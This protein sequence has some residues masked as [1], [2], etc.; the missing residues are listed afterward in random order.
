MA[1]GELNTASSTNAVAIGK[2]CLHYFESSFCLFFLCFKG[3]N[4]TA[5]GEGA[6]ALG[7]SS[8]ATARFAVTIPQYYYIPQHVSNDGP[9]FTEPLSLLANML[10]QV[11]NMPLPK[12]VMR[13]V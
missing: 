3:F 11:R 4:N 10:L 6:V 2:L 13:K 8:Q 9:A 12:A 7:R 5:S 1:I